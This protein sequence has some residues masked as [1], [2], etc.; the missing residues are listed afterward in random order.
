[1][2]LRPFLHVKNLG[3]LHG[4]PRTPRRGELGWIASH[5]ETT[6]ITHSTAVLAD[7]A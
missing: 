2:T 5:T 1:M 4:A 7:V 3:R 6:V